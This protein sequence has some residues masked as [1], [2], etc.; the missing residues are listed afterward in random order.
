MEINK[1]FKGRNCLTLE[2]KNKI[3][4]LLKK[5]RDEGKKLNL[6]KVA[7]KFEVSDRTIRRVR[8]NID[9]L[10]DKLLNMKSNVSLRK[11][12]G[13]PSK[14]VVEQNLNE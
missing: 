1:E 8:D 12:K 3:V 11:R 4:D 6:T 14:N 9:H 2:G 10:H 5:A 7:E 13:L